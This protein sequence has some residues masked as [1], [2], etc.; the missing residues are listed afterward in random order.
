VKQRVCGVETADCA[1]LSL[2]GHV[3]R[4]V[5]HERIKQPTFNGST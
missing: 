5:T 1:E 3:E 2:A 4:L